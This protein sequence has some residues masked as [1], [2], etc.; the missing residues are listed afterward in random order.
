MLHRRA[1]HSPSVP[2]DSS[3]YSTFALSF[4]AHRVD[5][6]AAKRAPSPQQ[7]TSQREKCA[8]ERSNVL[9]TLSPSRYAAPFHGLSAPSGKL[10][11]RLLHFRVPHPAA[12]Q[13]GLASI[14]WDASGCLHS[15]GAVTSA[16][17]LKPCSSRSGRVS[18]SSKGH[19]SRLAPVPQP[20]VG[21]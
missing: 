20:C 1:V 11:C 10:G 16:V 3:A 4:W 18:C 8:L 9:F 13:L 17:F 12:Q 21:V 5:V 2:A 14:T 19:S 15:V 6:C 7:G